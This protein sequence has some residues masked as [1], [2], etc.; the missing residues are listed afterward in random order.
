MRGPLPRGPEKKSKSSGLWESGV[1]W[2]DW[3]VVEVVVTMQW[4][5]QGRMGH[6]GVSVP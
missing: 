5:S 6:V 3:C 2:R 4:V 1:S